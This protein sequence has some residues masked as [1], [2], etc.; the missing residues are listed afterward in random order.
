MPPAAEDNIVY[1]SYA[2]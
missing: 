1:C 2:A